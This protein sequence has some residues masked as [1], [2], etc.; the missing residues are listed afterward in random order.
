MSKW[1]I[2]NNVMFF[3]ARKCKEEGRGYSEVEMDIIDLCLSSDDDPL[4][5]QHTLSDKDSHY[6]HRDPLVIQDKDGDSGIQLLDDVEGNGVSYGKEDR[7]V[8][9]DVDLLGLVR[10]RVCDVCIVSWN[11]NGIRALDNKLGVSHIIL[12]VLDSPD[13]VC[14]QESKT[15]DSTLL[16]DDI[17][18]VEGYES[19]WS[20][21][22]VK[23]GYSG[24]VTYAKK[25]I[26]IEANDRIFA[27]HDESEKEN[28]NPK[29]DIFDNEGRVI[30]TDH[31]SFVLFNV[32]FPNGCGSEARLEYKLQFYHSFSSICDRYLEQGRNVIVVGDVNTSA[33]EI[34]H[35]DPD[36]TRSGFL[37]SERAWLE[38]FKLNFLD[39][40]RH[41]H[42]DEVKYSWWDVQKNHRAANKGN[43][44]DYCF[45][46]KNLKDNLI[47]SDVLI[48]HIGSD[49]CPVILKLKE[50]TM[51]EG[52]PAPQ[53]S[54]MKR[55]KQM[56]IQSFFHTKNSKKRKRTDT[57][58]KNKTK[59]RKLLTV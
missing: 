16:K 41:C 33:D 37:P 27:L 4:I 26:T 15:H 51:K 50:M 32:Y 23:K 46:N 55:M 29:G 36:E 58:T 59:K 35:W 5:T 25:G 34:D 17:I 21:C 18:H 12:E 53:L 13:I 38:S 56:K 6:D 8:W 28:N 9:V 11:V 24:V 43:R 14:F 49:H 1:W 39:C 7:S 52:C 22:S 48:E 3:L 54:S 2:Y 40:F 19:F 45:I 44:I 57:Q 20:C 42:P 47:D 30:M 31:G 10:E